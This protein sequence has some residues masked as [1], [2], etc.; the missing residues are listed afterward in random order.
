MRSGPST[1]PRIAIVGSGFAG[2]GMAIRLLRLGIESFT[3]YEAGDTP[4]GT[5]R[6]NTYPGA[7]CDVPSHLYSFSFEPN[8][9]WSRTYGTQREILAYLL[10]CARRYDVERF[11]RCRSRVSAARFD[12]A[13]GVW[14]IDVDCDGARR[15]VEADLLIAASGPLSRPAMPDIDG[16]ERFEGRLFHSARWDHDYALDG[17]RVGVIGTG[18]SA[19]QFVPQ[20]QPR[21]ARLTVFQRTAPWVLPRRDL[22]IGPRTQ[23]LFA[24]LPLA[25]RIVR[26]AIYWQLE[27]H[28]L[29]FIAKPRLMRGS[30]KFAHAYLARKIAD[31]ALRA[32][33]TP[34]Y[35]LGCKRVL[36]SSDY[37]PALAQPNVDV[38]TTAIREI[39]A[40][41]IV[42]ADGAHHPLD[43]I[44]CGTGFR[45]NDADAPFE[46]VGANG[47]DLGAAWRRDGPQAYLGTTVAGFPN[48]FLLAGPNTGL[49]H[50]SMIY[51]IE[52][53][54]RYVADCIRA[55]RRNGARSM[56]VRADVQHAFNE[57]LQR[58]MKRSVWQS[59]C[60]SWYQTKDGRNTAI[61]PGF[62][63]EFRR[64]TRR[65]RERDYVF[66]R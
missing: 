22:A 46:I 40:D 33:L 41:G 38:V 19:I 14:T 32:K 66:A 50:S 61:W 28:A 29:A 15:T 27:A 65:V 18:A 57:R 45:F 1:T 25:Q 44:V 62:T 4:G 10:H 42:T 54:I 11:I 59:G 60:R 36:L 8:P 23:R 51:M 3:I 43:A 58:D 31:P 26:G 21:V 64:R 37:Y 9:A 24:R 2:I 5:W 17:M 35:V 6:D 12:D 20:I 30:M 48:L 13:R 47:A 63:F 39:V 34:D 56:A 55:L 16:I 53:Q 49:G 7:A 52:S